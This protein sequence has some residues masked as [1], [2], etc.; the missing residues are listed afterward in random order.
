MTENTKL[1]QQPVARHW[2]DWEWVDSAVHGRS[3]NPATGEVIGMFAVGT[4]KDAAGAVD[5]ALRTFNYTEWKDN[6]QLRSRV[7]NELADRFEAKWSRAPQRPC[8]YGRFFRIQT[9]CA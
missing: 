4:K 8:G 3:I 7:L 1:E 5:V 9:Y 6:P 2:I